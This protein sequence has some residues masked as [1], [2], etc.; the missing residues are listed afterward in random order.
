MAD[1]LALSLDGGAGLIVDDSDVELLNIL[2]P[3]M[4][5]E[6]WCR[7]DEAQAL[8]PL[9][10]PSSLHLVMLWAETAL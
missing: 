3:P 6:A 5:L 2:E 7:A 4:T 8:R 9:R 1:D 10:L